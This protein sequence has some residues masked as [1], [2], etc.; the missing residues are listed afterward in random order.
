[1]IA[2][3]IVKERPIPLGIAESLVSL[4]NSETSDLF[5]LIKA[6]TTACRVHRNWVIYP[7]P[8]LRKIL[9]FQPG[10]LKRAV[11]IAVLL[12]PGSRYLLST[13]F[14]EEEQQNRLTISDIQ[15]QIV[16]GVW[17]FSEDT[18][19][20]AYRSVEDGAAVMFAFHPGTVGPSVASSNLPC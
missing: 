6:L 3:E 7:Q 13:E 5:S 9:V 1:M 15:L 12:T 11:D 14:Y 10:A 19:L 18:R 20:L 2:E 8:R 17:C 16:L 4:A